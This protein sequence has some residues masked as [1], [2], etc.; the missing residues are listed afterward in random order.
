[1]IKSV[2]RRAFANMTRLTLLTMEGMSL[3]LLPENLLA[4]LPN[5]ERVYFINCKIENIPEKFF[6]YQK[7]MKKLI[8]SE[9]SIMVLHKGLFESSLKLQELDL[10]GN[11]LKSIYVDFTKLRA[12]ERIFLIG[13]SCLDLLWER[14]IEKSIGKFQLEVRSRC[15]A[16]QTK[17]DI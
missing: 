16:Q 4:D 6:S 8:L 7:N 5:L 15:T 14:V 12:I 3:D 1:M 11:S 17:Q 10:T 2:E 9:N 13:N